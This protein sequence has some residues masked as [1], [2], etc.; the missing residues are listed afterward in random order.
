MRLYPGMGHLINEDEIDAV[1]RMM[2]A[3]P[4]ASAV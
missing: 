3:V 4:D 2:I 1:R